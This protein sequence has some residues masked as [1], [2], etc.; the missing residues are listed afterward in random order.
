MLVRTCRSLA[1]ASARIPA[2]ASAPDNCAAMAQT[3]PT[4]RPL[5]KSNMEQQLGCGR[6]AS[7][8]DDGRDGMAKLGIQADAVLAFVRDIEV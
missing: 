1:G 7:G 6:E 5:V 3:H 8:S 4:C 2:G